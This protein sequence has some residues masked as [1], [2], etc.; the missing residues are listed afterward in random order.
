MIEITLQHRRPNGSIAMVILDAT[1]RS[2][3][4][5]NRDELKDLLFR[6]EVGANESGDIRA[7]IFMKEE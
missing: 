2:M 3:D 6:T 4:V 7:H 5:K 1:I